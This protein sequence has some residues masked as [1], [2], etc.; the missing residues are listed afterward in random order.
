MSDAALENSQDLLSGRV[1]QGR[2]ESGLA[3][4]YVH[5]F[6]L[7]S[8]LFVSYFSQTSSFPVSSACDL[9][10][11]QT[12]FVKRAAFKTLGSLHSES[13][14]LPRR[15]YQFIQVSYL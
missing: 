15:I 1:D 9:H 2:V 8:L 3:K 10:G 5:S 14:S 11:L 7:D 4:D 12:I 13:K 6:I